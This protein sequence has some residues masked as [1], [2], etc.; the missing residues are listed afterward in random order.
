MYTNYTKYMY[1]H[2]IIFHTSFLYTWKGRLPYFTEMLLGHNNARSN[3]WQVKLNQYFGK[4]QYLTRF[5]IL[6]S[7]YKLIVLK[8]ILPVFLMT[9]VVL[10]MWYLRPVTILT[11][12]PRVHT[13]CCPHCRR[14]SSRARS[15]TWL[16]DDG[17]FSLS[18]TGVSGTVSYYKTLSWINNWF[19]TPLTLIIFVFY[20]L[21]L[22]IN[23][24]HVANRKMI[25]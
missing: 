24:F 11:P 9:S 5:Y 4:I 19:L 10:M 1:K 6:K 21:G 2:K 23:E 25:D 8:Q 14:R 20:F 18:E 3:Q 12:C 22:W 17:M 15:N 16:N 7:P 13:P